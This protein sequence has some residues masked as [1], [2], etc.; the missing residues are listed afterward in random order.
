MN[1]QT[2]FTVLANIATGL[3]CLV[4]LRALLHKLSS[5]D[6]FV[7]VVRDYRLVSRPRLFALAL[8]TVEALTLVG[9]VWPRTRESAAMLA[10]SLL[11]LYVVAI[12]VNLKRGRTTIDCGCGGGGQG[13]S[14]LHIVRNVMLIGLAAPVLWFDSL[15]QV[16]LGTSLANVSCVLVLWLTFLAFDQLLDNRM[17]A[18]AS[19]HSTL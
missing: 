14:G 15:V 9:L 4:F 17:H 3:L 7:G 8:I 13:I 16:Q 19:A 11:A 2:S 10:M 18:V 5:F 1:T 12:A 6:S